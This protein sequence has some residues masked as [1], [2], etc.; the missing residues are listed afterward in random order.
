MKSKTVLLIFLL[1][2]DT[3]FCDTKE[4]IRPVLPETETAVINVRHDF[5]KTKI[6]VFSYKKQCD[7]FAAESDIMDAVKGWE[8]YHSVCNDF[9]TYKN[10]EEVRKKEYL[11]KEAEFRREENRLK[12]ILTRKKEPIEKAL[13]AWLS[14]P[15]SR[16]KETEVKTLK[17]HLNELEN[18]YSDEIRVLREN[19][20]PETA[21]YQNKLS[22]EEAAKNR[23]IEK[24]G[25]NR[26]SF[27]G[28]GLSFSDVMNSVITTEI[29]FSEVPEKSMEFRFEKTD[30]E[31]IPALSEIAIGYA[32]SGIR[33]ELPQ[34][35]KDFRFHKEKFFSFI[36]ET[37]SGKENLFEKPGE[38]AQAMNLSYCMGVQRFSGKKK[39]GISNKKRKQTYDLPVSFSVEKGDVEIKVYREG[40]GIYYF[41]LPK[42]QTGSLAEHICLILTEEQLIS[43]TD[44]YRN[45]EPQ[46]TVIKNPDFITFDEFL[47]LEIRLEESGFILSDNIIKRIENRIF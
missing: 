25:L 30:G 39:A 16:Q 6:E 8:L 22:A 5:F 41:L 43:I 44:S 29:I 26:K 3:L 9:R 45:K 34:I 20:L 32:G 27:E 36:A 42:V 21:A 23:V 19:I 4:N 2:S 17:N 24:Y 46:K 28:T 18:F 31:E 15:E 12:E 40:T 7:I 37:V 11:K 33:A 14:Q 1:L 35:K 38:K 13:S 10:E 47:P